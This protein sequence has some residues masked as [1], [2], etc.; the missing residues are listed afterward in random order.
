M[1]KFIYEFFLFYDEKAS[2]QLI[3]SDIKHH[4]QCMLL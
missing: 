2:Q 4:K 1:T 3:V